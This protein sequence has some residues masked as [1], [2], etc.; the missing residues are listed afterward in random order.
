MANFL[1][2]TSCACFA[3]VAERN[4]H[5]EWVQQTHRKSS[6]ATDKEIFSEKLIN[7]VLQ[8]SAIMHFY[9]GSVL[10][11]V[12][13]PIKYIIYK[14]GL[15]FFSPNTK[16]QSI[17][18]C[19]HQNELLFKEVCTKYWTYWFECQDSSLQF[20]CVTCTCIENN[21]VFQFIVTNYCL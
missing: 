1:S 7:C 16:S 8:T 5:F 14:A 12:I 11:T 2:Y 19:L 17:R 3:D 4:V 15:F 9:G 6:G 10:R 18:F 21:N 13:C 20:I